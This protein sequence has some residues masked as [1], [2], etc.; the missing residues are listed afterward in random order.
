MRRIGVLALQG[1]F[2]PHVARLRALGLSPVE[3]RA[4]GDLAGCEGLI[5]PGGESTTQACLLERDPELGVALDTFVAS[6]PT[7]AT[8]AG[9]I[10]AA[11]RGW[12]DATLE[13]NGYGPQLHSA[14]VL[15]DDGRPLVLIRAPRVRRVGPGVEVLARLDGEPV[16]LRSGTLLGATFHPE[17]TEDPS[18]FRVAFGAPATTRGDPRWG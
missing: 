11:R 17:L 7:L 12:I 15:A 10:L 9:L 5:L 16:L 6:R 1:G 2:A 8:C 14:E 18:L 13:R 3:V 4:R